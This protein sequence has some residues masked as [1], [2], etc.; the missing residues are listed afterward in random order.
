MGVV[1]PEWR[2]GACCVWGRSAEGAHAGSPQGDFQPC[3]GFTGDTG[4]SVK[5][6]N[7]GRVMV[8]SSFGKIAIT[9]MENY[10]K[11]F[12]FSRRKAG[13]EEL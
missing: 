10:S 5:D 13:I 2:E 12:G 6:F 11:A 8:T 4:E 3:L 7:Q 9:Q 1:P